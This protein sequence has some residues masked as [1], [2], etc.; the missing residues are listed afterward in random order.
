MV[1]DWWNRSRVIEVKAKDFQ[2][3]YVGIS[4]VESTAA[5]VERRG[6]TQQPEKIK[7]ALE[8]MALLETDLKE[9][10]RRLRFARNFDAIMDYFAAVADVRRYEAQLR[11]RLIVDLQ[12]TQQCI[13]GAYADRDKAE[14]V[15]LEA[16]TERYAAVSKVEA[17]EYTCRTQTSKAERAQALADS[18]E[19]DLRDMTASWK[20]E[21]ARREELEA[22]LQATKDK[23]SAELLDTQM[24]LKKVTVQH[25]R[26][27][28]ELKDTQAKLD[29]ALTANAELQELVRVRTL[30]VA[31]LMDE[32]A[33]AEAS[34]GYFA[35]QFAGDGAVSFVIGAAFDEVAAT[36]VE[37]TR[38]VATQAPV[39][40]SKG[41]RRGGGSSRGGSKP[42]SRASS[43][44]SSR[45]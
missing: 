17:I 14:A 12:F 27:A 4:S 5:Q 31:H 38:A 26:S 3:V 22:E 15:A 19:G 44:A 8:E 35:D 13:D 23:M 20:A 29:T 32:V 10:E 6:G 18:L 16:R 43:R 45:R 42:G 33:T 30:E 7:E 11:D 36:V 41:S 24:K 28:Q 9:T 21:R 37:A 34:A 40:P 2:P 39:S 1:M 25:S